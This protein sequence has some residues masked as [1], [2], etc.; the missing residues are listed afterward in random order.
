MEY[1]HDC[2]GFLKLS[3]GFYCKNCKF[4]YVWIKNNLYYSY[5]ENI[6]KIIESKYNIKINIL[7]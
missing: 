7:N 5:F 4:R 3:D 6:S 2:I 1:K